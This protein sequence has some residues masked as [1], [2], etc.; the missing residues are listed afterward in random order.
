MKLLLDENLSVRLVD[1]LRE[2]Y[3]DIT[4]VH[5][6]GLGA[7]DDREVWNFARQHGLAIV[8]RDTGFAERS[9]LAEN[10]PKIIKDHL[11]SSW[12]LLYKRHRKPAPFC[13]DHHPVFH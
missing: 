8:S 10:P 9:V 13:T 5:C 3:S 12:K 4:H 7:A 6:K 2:T 1:A 11:D